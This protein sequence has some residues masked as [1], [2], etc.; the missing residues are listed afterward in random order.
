[1]D[2]LPDRIRIL[3]ALR[4]QVVGDDA[5]LAQARTTGALSASQAFDERLRIGALR[6]DDRR[7]THEL[8]RQATAADPA[9]ASRM[10]RLL[11]LVD[12]VTMLEH[13]AAVGDDPS[14]RLAMAR[15]A[16]GELVAEAGALAQAIAAAHER[17]ASG[18]QA[19]G[20]TTGGLRLII[21]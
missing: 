5:A 6:A 19:P 17:A 9:L 13:E 1:M 8:R 12:E 7:L 10:E 14:M 21:S 18:T 3:R 20:P 16:E 2:D 4:S 15:Q 11:M